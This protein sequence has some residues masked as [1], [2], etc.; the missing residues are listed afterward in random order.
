MDARV[1]GGTTQ[2][3][4]GIVPLIE[5]FAKVTQSPHHYVPLMLINTKESSSFYKTVEDYLKKPLKEASS[6]AG[7]GCNYKID[8]FVFWK[9]NCPRYLSADLCSLWLLSGKSW[10][11]GKNFCLWCPSTPNDSGCFEKWNSVT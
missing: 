10:S 4:V 8:W 3:L 9:L 7:V 1:I 2:V 6:F 11:G 5:G